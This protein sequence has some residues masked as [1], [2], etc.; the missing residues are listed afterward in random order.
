M[1]RSQWNFTHTVIN[2]EC[3]TTC[4]S[5]FDTDTEDTEDTENTEKVEEIEEI[6]LPPPGRHYRL[7]VMDVSPT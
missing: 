1:S 7:P 5:V 3:T 2:S 4:T 6:E